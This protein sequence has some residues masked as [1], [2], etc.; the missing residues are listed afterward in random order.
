MRAEFKFGESLG[1][2]PRGHEA[3]E[4]QPQPQPRTRISGTETILLVEHQPSIR[5]HMV[6]CL[7][8]LAYRVL[9]TSDASAALATLRQYKAGIDLLLTDFSMPGM[10]GPELSRVVALERPGIKVLYMSGYPE[11]LVWETEFLKQRPCWLAKPFTPQQLAAGVRKALGVRRRAVLVVDEDSEVR[12]LVAKALRGGYDVLEASSLTMART[13]LNETRV[14]LMIG[15]L[16]RFEQQGEESVRNLRRLYPGT[17]IIVMTGSVPALSRYA[18]FKARWLRG[19][20]ATLPKPIS[21]GLLL[22]TAGKLLES[23]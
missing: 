6:S 19:A 17:R 7:Q 2:G 22:D 21:T 3:I 18:G 14:D 8:G 23:M 10:S 15:D 13:V 16:A 12:A 1:A 11:E 4:R 20:D 9:A 5:Q